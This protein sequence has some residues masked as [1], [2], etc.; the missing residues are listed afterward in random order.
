MLPIVGVPE[1]RRRGLARARGPQP[2]VDGGTARAGPDAWGAPE[3]ACGLP[4]A[5]QARGT[6]CGGRARLCAEPGGR[7]ARG[8]RRPGSAVAQRNVPSRIWKPSWGTH[9]NAL[10]TAVPASGTSCLALRGYAKWALTG[11]TCATG[12]PRNTRVPS[13]ECFGFV[14]TLDTKPKRRLYEVLHAQ[15]LQMHQDMI[16]MAMEVKEMPAAA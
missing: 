7:E 4:W 12:S 5:P 2:G 16:F 3:S 15:G 1:P 6:A 8:I 13:S 11:G 9:T 14:Q 10:L